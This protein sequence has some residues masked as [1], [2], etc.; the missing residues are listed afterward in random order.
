MPSLS[1]IVRRRWPDLRGP[2]VVAVSGG[3]DS[4]VLLRVL[5]MWI[6]PL[7]VA[8]L[9]HRLRET[10]SSSWIERLTRALR[11]AFARP[12][13]AVAAMCLVMAAGLLLQNSRTGVAPADDSHARV[14][15]IEPEQVEKALDDMQM[16][17]ELSSA[18]STDA[19]SPKTL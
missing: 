16:L 18:P 4:V 3:A 7:V 15:K 1:E 10:D 11:P 12:A 9:N 14:E 13:L 2:G 17:R 19:A 8:H 5:A 6:D